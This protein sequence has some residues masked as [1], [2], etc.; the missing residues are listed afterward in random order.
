MRCHDAIRR[1]CLASN[2]AA[3]SDASSRN[4]SGPSHSRALPPNADGATGVRDCQSNHG[5]N[6]RITANDQPRRR[7]QCREL[8]CRTVRRS[9]RGCGERVRAISHADA[10]PPGRKRRDPSHE[11]R[12]CG[13]PSARRA[14][15]R[16]A[17]GHQTSSA[18]AIGRR[19]VSLQYADVT[20]PSI[21]S[22]AVASATSC[23]PS[24]STSGASSPTSCLRSRA[25]HVGPH[26]RTLADEV[27]LRS[28]RSSSR[29]RDPPVSPC[30]RFPGRR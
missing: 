6:R 29:G 15:A 5:K 10:G 14:S 24:S 23:A 2:G 12:W 19:S 3:S 20:C 18:S 11:P 25:Q 7:R 4:S 27:P 13:P 26:Q 9:G 28:C 8:H 1:R 17:R 16:S 22:G 21:G 30:H